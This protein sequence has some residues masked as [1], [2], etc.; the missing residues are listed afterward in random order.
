MRCAELCPDVPKCISQS[1]LAQELCPWCFWVWMDVSSF[2]VTVLVTLKCGI[3]PERMDGIPARVKCW[4]LAAIENV[5]REI[6]KHISVPVAEF[7]R[8]VG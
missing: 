2:L 3:V 8:L 1:L 5:T 6:A 7:F 4:A